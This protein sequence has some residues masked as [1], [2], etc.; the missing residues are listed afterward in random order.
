MNKKNT[1][2]LFGERITDGYSCADSR[3]YSTKQQG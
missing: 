1:V 2:F 3:R